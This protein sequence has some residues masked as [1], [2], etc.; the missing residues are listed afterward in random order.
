MSFPIPIWQRRIAMPPKV[1]QDFQVAITTFFDAFCAECKKKYRPNSLSRRITWWGSGNESVN[2]LIQKNIF[3]S[4]TFSIFLA[5]VYHNLC[6][7]KIG[8]YLRDIYNLYN[9]LRECGTSMDDCKNN[10][11][12][13]EHRYSKL[14][15]I[16]PT[17][18]GYFLI[19]RPAW[20]WIVS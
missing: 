16:L 12:A 13:R 15:L 10:T 3:L 14:Y 1:L 4:C 2:L 18:E 7:V 11:L 8:H 9:S 17:A 20:D 5:F 6:S 19:D